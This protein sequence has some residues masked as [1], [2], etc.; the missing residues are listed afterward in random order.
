LGT[1]PGAGANSVVVLDF[2]IAAVAAEVTV[3]GF[4]ASTYAIIAKNSCLVAW[5][6]ISYCNIKT[7]SEIQP[8]SR[9][10]AKT[11]RITK[12]MAILAVFVFIYGGG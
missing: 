6:L 5:K 1:S 7:V 9:I 10:D 2:E 4:K 12:S 8:L 11:A 3:G